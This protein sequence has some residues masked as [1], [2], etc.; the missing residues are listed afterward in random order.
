MR[1]PPAP[2][3]DRLAPLVIL[4]AA[5]LVRTLHPTTN[6]ARRWGED[7]PPCATLDHVETITLPLIRALDPHPPVATIEVRI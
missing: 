6:R 5:R 7:S 3:V 4:G 1:R 2:H